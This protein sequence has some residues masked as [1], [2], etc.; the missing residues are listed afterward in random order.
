MAGKATAGRHSSSPF[1]AGNQHPDGS[2]GKT[3]L[4]PGGYLSGKRVR[5]SP[6]ELTRIVEES[7][8]IK[9][10]VDSIGTGNTARA[11]LCATGEPE[12]HVVDR[13][14]QGTGCSSTSWPSKRVSRVISLNPLNLRSFRRIRQSPKDWLRSM[15]SSKA[16]L[17]SPKLGW[18]PAAKSH[19]RYC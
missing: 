10:Q 16:W 7:S 11:R 2:R 1:P 12:M 3:P 14:A 5:Q 9:V 6:L 15:N 13:D 4:G 8:R 17:Q 18:P 19:G